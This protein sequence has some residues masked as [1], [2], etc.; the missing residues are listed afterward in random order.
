LGF[1]TWNLG[2]PFLSTSIP[3]HKQLSSR[4]KSFEIKKSRFKKIETAFLYLSILK[5]S[6]YSDQLLKDLDLHR[7]PPVV[8]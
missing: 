5:I 2:S 6:I 7:F 1:G 8:F 4:L 3:T